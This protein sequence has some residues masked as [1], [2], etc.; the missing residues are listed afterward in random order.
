MAEDDKHNCGCRGADEGN[1]SKTS[2]K[3]RTFLATGAAVSLATVAGCLGRT[4][5]N[6]SGGSNHS[7]GPEPPWTTEDLLDQVEDGTTVTIYA[8]SGNTKTWNTLVDVINDEFDIE[9]EANVF[10]SGGSRVSQRFIQERQTGNDKADVLTYVSDIREKIG[11]EGESVARKYFEWGMDENFW[12][13]D[14]MPDQRLVPYRVSAF[15]GVAGLV[16]PINADMFDE[17][18]LDRPDDYN[19]LFDDQYEG[20]TMVMPTDPNLTNL[21]WIISYHA[22]KTDMS[23]REW[24]TSL[25]DRFELLKVSS[26]STGAQEVT[27]G[28]APFMLYNYASVL[29]GSVADSPLEGY[30]PKPVM[31][32]S[33]SGPLYIN[34]NAPNPWAGRLFVSAMLE[35]PI[36][37]RI[38][39]EVPAMTPVRQDVDYSTVDIDEYTRKR[40]T[41][42]VDLLTWEEFPEYASLGEK[43]VTE[44]LDL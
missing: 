20:L 8:A 44:W 41:T 35:A 42:E 2:I 16:M 1:N 3:R 26:H 36:Q 38:I 6:N 43:A 19:D 39:N 25:L 14:V 5:S 12:Y 27:S 28:N 34:K 23:E 31:A 17:Q 9:L 32:Q 10:N 24:I 22:A 13:T 7:D 4:E 37:R 30:F 21:A 11:Q 29:D 15:D 33:W 40:L 18:G